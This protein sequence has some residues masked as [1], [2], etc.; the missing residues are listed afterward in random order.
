LRDLTGDACPFGGKVIILGGDFRQL[1]PVVPGANEPEHV[2]NTVLHH[3]SMQE[4]YVTRFSL[5]TNMRLLHGAGGEDTSHRDWL[6]RLSSG[7]LPVVTALRQ[8]AVELP[9]HLCMPPGAAV[10]HVVAWIFPDARARVQLCLTGASGVGPSSTR[11]TM[12]P[13]RSIH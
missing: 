5:T 2:A 10:E 11:A 13:C 9:E 4:G 12:W 1:L 7:L 3:P 6:L 8:H